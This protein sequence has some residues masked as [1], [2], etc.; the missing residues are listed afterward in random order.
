MKLF[1]REI[2]RNNEQ[3]ETKDEW[4]EAM[5]DVEDFSKH[6]KQVETS[7]DEWLDF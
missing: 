3:P 7:Q 4:S 2:G 6:M 5:E 1:G